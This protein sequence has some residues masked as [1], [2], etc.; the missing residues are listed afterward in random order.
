M[1]IQAIHTANQV[2]E[3][4]AGVHL[5]YLFANQVPE[6]GAGVHLIYLFA[7]QVPVFT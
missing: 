4:G 7:N 2:P 1:V 5:I 3:P 6:P